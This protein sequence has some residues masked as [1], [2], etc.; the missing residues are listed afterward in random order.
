MTGARSTPT[1]ALAVA[2]VALLLGA[3]GIQS[4]SAPRNV[5]DGE[6]ALDNSSTS[7]GTDASGADRIY[8]AAP[9]DDRRLR[10]V[11]RDAASPQ[12]LIK[13]LLL[14]PN[15]DEKAAQFTSF[16]PPTT[17]LI[18]ARA[19][20]QF[21]IL[22]LSEE[23]TELTPQSLMQAIAQIVY[24]ATEIDGIEAVQLKVNDQQLSWPKPNGDTTTDPLRI[25]D[26]PNFVQ[27]AQP[28][29]PAVPAS[30]DS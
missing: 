4:D 9:G 8:L 25:Y 26:Y 21:L 18:S 28:A 11:T 3:C 1:A 23:I 7:R 14:G 19:Q 2:L 17:E 16:I 27:T 13:I 15:D 29:Y 10:S 22:D 24:T 6:R 5:P 12:D 20:G 30:P